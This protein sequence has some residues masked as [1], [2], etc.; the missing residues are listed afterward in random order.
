[1]P[2]PKPVETITII[3]EGLEFGASLLRMCEKGTLPRDESF[4]QVADNLIRFLPRYVEELRR[5]MTE[6]DRES[7]AELIHRNAPPKR[8]QR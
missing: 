7:I 4:Q 6:G 3:A 5:L 2:V 8:K 1:M